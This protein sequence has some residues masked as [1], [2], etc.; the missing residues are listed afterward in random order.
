MTAFVGRYG[1]FCIR[2]SVLVKLGW[3]QKSSCKKT[4]ERIYDLLWNFKLFIK[5]ASD[6]TPTNHF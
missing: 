3:L 5:T 2:K 1:S 6:L 4:T